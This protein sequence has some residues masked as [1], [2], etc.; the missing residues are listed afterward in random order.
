MS[1]VWIIRA[2]PDGADSRLDRWREI[3]RGRRV[4]LLTWGGARPVDGVAIPGRPVMGSRWMPLAY[5]WFMVAVLLVGLFSFRRGDRVV[6]IDLEALLGV[7]LAAVL[8]GS[9]IHFDVADPF[10]LAKP[11]ACKAFWRWLEGR[12]IATVSLATAPHASRFELYV[13]AGRGCRLVVENVPWLEVQPHVPLPAQTSP[14]VLGYF[15]ALEPHRGLEDLIELVQ[16][17][18]DL[19]LHVAGHGS[20]SMLIQRAASECPRIVFSGRF[21]SEQLPLLVRDVHVYC[22]LY[23][24]LKPLHDY[25]CPNKFYEH[26]ALARPILISRCVP[27]AA[28]VL[29]HMSGWVVDGDGV[30]AIAAQLHHIDAAAV[31]DR[32]GNAARLWQQRYAGYYSRIRKEMG[33]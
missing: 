11:V 14:L 1:A 29:E 27:M 17:N 7:W 16:S 2:L 8:H 24:R 15:G 12:C 10:H 28:D 18:K 21:R 4:R 3:Y 33:L 9:D 23:Y 32:A 22:S 30:A 20:L 26:L 5:P 25:A 19:A 6:C 31:A 13:A